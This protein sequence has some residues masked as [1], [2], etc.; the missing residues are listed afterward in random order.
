MSGKDNDSLED[1]F[2]KATQQPELQFNE[3]DWSKMEKKLDEELGKPVAAVVPSRGRIIG[4]MVLAGALGVLTLIWWRSANSNL[5]DLAQDTGTTVQPTIPSTHNTPDHTEDP[6]PTEPPADVAAQDQRGNVTPPKSDHQISVVDTDQIESP[7]HARSSEEETGSL[8]PAL[9]GGGDGTE[10]TIVTDAS[11]SESPVALPVSPGFNQSQ[12]DPKDELYKER[13]SGDHSSGLTPAGSDQPVDSASAV[14]IADALATDEPDETAEEGSRKAANVLDYG[15]FGISIVAAPDFSMTTKGGA[16]GSGEALGVML[17]YQVFNRWGITAGALHNFKK[18]WGYGNE[19]HPP[20][21]YWKALTNGVI[22]DRVDGTC[23]LYEIPVAVTFDVVRTQ[24]SR[25]FASAGLSS[26][27]M[28]NEDYYYT[29]D[30]PNPGAVT[31]WS[32]DKP[33]T[34]WFGIGTLSVGYDFRAT[35]SLSFGVEPYFKVPLE[36]IGWADIDL[37]STGV[38]FAA[39]YHFMKN[40]S[41]HPP[42]S[43]GP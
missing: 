15:R 40:G 9:P 14:I 8:Q 4:L 37:Y 1:F 11:Q 3:D 10:N 5:E 6:V 2:R 32:G 27:F 22:P 33:S 31:G 39:R 16:M 17:H 24:R 18:Y 36:G 42:P 29:F 26:Y 38:L 19:Y 35:R 23:A 41:K 30:N 28:R 20:S 43:K 21:G 7:A 25:L 13:E 12:A 34:L